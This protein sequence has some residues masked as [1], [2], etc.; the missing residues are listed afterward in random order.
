MNSKQQM[1]ITDLD[2]S[3]LDNEQQITDFTKIIFNKC[4]ENGCII[5]FATARP[6]RATVKFF[7]SIY[8]DAVICHNGAVVCVNGKQIYQSGIKTS[9]ARN[10]LK[11]IISVYP[12][13]S[14]AVEN[15]DTILSNF[16]P[17]IYWKG[18]IYNVIDIEN[19]PETDMDKLIVIMDS[20]KK[21]KE[22]EKF[23]PKNLYLRISENKYGYIMNKGATKW[24][25][26]NKLLKY[27]KI[28]KKKSIAFGDD[29]NDLEMIKNS[30]TGIAMQNSVEE[31][32][33]IAKYVCGKNYEDG[34]ARWIK[35][36]I[37]L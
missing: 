25:G 12:D 29:F 2:S 27:Y 20:V 13:A 4:K 23:L 18:T 10:L 30:G 7:V 8:P 5:V 9:I 15:N 32:K 33:K 21:I 35:E 14:L 19:L 17:S 24:N 22:V 16:D 26:I 6:L 31:V 34:V 1:I 11:K 36:N 37:L 3:L 28:G